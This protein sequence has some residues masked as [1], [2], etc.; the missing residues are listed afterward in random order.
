M[1]PLVSVIIPIYNVE[2]YLAECLQSVKNNILF[3][4]DGEIEVLLVNDGSTDNSSKIANEFSKENNSFHYIEQPNAGLS[5]ARNT[6]VSKAIGEY[7]F[8]LDSDDFLESET[9]RS[10]YNFSV[11]NDCDICQCGMLYYYGDKRNYES[12]D[13]RGFSKN[14]ILTSVEAMRL[15]IKNEKIK[16]F[17]CGKL[18]KTNLVK[19]HSFKVGRYFEDLFWQPEVVGACIVYGVLNKSYYKYRQR[20][21]SITGQFSLRKFDLLDGYYELTEYVKKQYPLLYKLSV[22]KLWGT[23]IMFDKQLKESGIVLE[24]LDICRF[25]DISRKC[26]DCFEFIKYK[27]T[28]IMFNL[29]P[30]LYTLYRRTINAFIKVKKLLID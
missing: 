3:F 17:A 21:D 27:P 25:K 1:K 4:H 20:N 18:Y 19:Q 14:H 26:E 15:L 22:Q 2:L 9:L 8:F 30:A 5:A 7:I 11:E 6:G 28:Y 16:S 29:V 10:L 13:T 24:G 12:L 23:K